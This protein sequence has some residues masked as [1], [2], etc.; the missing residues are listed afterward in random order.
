MAESENRE[1]DERGV[2]LRRMGRFVVGPLDE[3]IAR[4]R[5]RG[6]HLAFRTVRPRTS[7]CAIREYV[8]HQRA[9]GDH[10]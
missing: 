5:I 10:A 7:T 2:R 6:F 8:Q 3:G 4:F 9:D 1:M